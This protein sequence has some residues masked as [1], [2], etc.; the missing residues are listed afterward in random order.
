MNRYALLID[1]L[2]R[3]PGV[4]LKHL[5]DVGTFPLTYPFFYLTSSERAATNESPPTLC[6]AAG[7]HGDEPA[8]VEAIVRFLE[9]RSGPGGA[10]LTVFPCL[11]PVGYDRGT[12]ENG[13]GLD[14]NRQFHRNDPPREVAMVRQAVAGCRYDLFLCCHEDNTAEGF[15][16]YEAKRGKRSSL[17]PSI[18]TTIREIISIDRRPVIDGRINRGGII[19]PRNWRYRKTGWSMSLYLYRRGTPHCLIFETPTHLPFEE[20]VRIH[21]TALLH[22]F[23]ILRERQRDVKTAL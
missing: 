4:A 20:R 2:A 1:R 10:V 18:I 9:K 8:G 12:R 11:N 16:L 14:L 17:S 13:E 6:L 21:M 19:R 5:G 15:Y 7:V 23:S 22:V 3:I